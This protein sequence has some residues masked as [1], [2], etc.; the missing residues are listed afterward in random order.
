MT[1]PFKKSFTLSKAVVRQ[2]FNTNKRVFW[3]KKWQ[4]EVDS[5]RHNLLLGAPNKRTLSMARI[6]HDSSLIG[7]SKNE[8]GVR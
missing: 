2:L 7:H 1:H 6:I 3:Q 8:G 4:I 5:I